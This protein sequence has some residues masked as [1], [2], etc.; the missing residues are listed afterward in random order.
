MVA[1][2]DSA[3]ALFKPDDTPSVPSPLRRVRRAGPPTEKPRRG[4]PRRPGPRDAQVAAGMGLAPNC[5]RRSSVTP[6]LRTNRRWRRRE[7]R[8]RAAQLLAGRSFEHGT[9]PT[10]PAP[11]SIS[12][13][14][15]QAHRSADDRG[16]IRKTSVD[17]DDIDDRHPRQCCDRRQQR[18]LRS[19]P[20]RA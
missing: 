9:R 10:T 1:G 15:D 7:S 11:R 18:H 14:R 12:Q 19:P 4:L 8:R 13:V 2:S 6:V 20:F 3:R 17:A 16:A 5:I